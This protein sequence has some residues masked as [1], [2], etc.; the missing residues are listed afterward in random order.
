[1]AHAQ[2]FSWFMISALGL[3]LLAVAVPPPCYLATWFGT[4][5]TCSGGC[6]GVYD[7]CPAKVLCNVV[8]TGTGPA[9]PIVTSPYNCQSFSGGTGTCPACTGG[10]PISQPATVTIP[11]QTCGTK[12]CP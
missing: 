5:T 4:S 12:A 7:V 8:P 2:K 1:M 11:N 3:P 10:T 6:A 9:D